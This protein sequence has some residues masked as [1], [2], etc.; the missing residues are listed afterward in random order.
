[1]GTGF[2]LGDKNVLELGGGGGIVNVL[3]TTK[4]H[5]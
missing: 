3:N 4:L 5:I 2:L 1:M